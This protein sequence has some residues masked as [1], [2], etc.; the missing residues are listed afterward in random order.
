METVLGG[1][2]IHLPVSLLRRFSDSSTQELLSWESRS[3]RNSPTVNRQRLIGWIIILRLIHEEMATKT[4]HRPLL[5]LEL[6]SLLMNGLM[7]PLAVIQEVVSEDPLWFK[8]SLE[9]VPAM[10]WSNSPMLCHC[11]QPWTL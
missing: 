9:I 10:A 8:D 11:P 7:L 4:L 1:I 2:Y 6:L 5:V 3:C